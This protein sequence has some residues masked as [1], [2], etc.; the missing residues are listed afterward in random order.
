[1]YWHNIKFLNTTTRN[2]RLRFIPI[3]SVTE[4]EIAKYGRAFWIESKNP[5]EMFQRRSRL[6]VGDMRRR[7]TE[8]QI[9]RN[10]VR[11][12]IHGR[13]LKAVLMVILCRIL[14][15]LYIVRGVYV[16]TWASSVRGNGS[17]CSMLCRVKER[18]WFGRRNRHCQLLITLLLRG[19]VGKALAIGCS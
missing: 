16:K 10:S 7:E 17:R 13:S 6:D 3:S 1:M 15:T 4:S 18:R 19:K 12:R 2:R 5:F 9:I 11:I 14:S 8:I